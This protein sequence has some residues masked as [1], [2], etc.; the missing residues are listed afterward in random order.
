MRPV[1]LHYH[2]LKN[3]GSTVEEILRRSLGAQ[4]CSFDHPHRDAEIKPAEIV[5]LLE[6]NPAV[7]A[8][9]SHQIF[10]PVPRAPGF[11]FF[12]IC[13]LRDPFDRIRSIYDYFRGKPAEDDPIRL[14]AQ[15]HTLR[16]FVRRLIDEMPWTV[17]DVQVNLLANGLVNDTPR[18]A[19][20]LDLATR[21]MLETSFLG[22]VDCFEESLVAGEYAARTLFPAVDCAQERV[23]D[24][25]RPGSTL[26]E[27]LKQFRE[28]CGEDVFR[29]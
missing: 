11:L 13:F 8:F 6:R 20:D 26:P 22:V 12:D 19:G 24:S 2:I 18:G 29:K 21:R 25:A 23:N 10:Y 14:L 15:R 4:F 16:D 7:T 5:Q 9:S 1:L 3:G 17:N 28:D 27:R